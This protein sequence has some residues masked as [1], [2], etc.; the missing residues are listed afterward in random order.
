MAHLWA[1]PLALAA[2]ATAAQKAA[3]TAQF[4]ESIK[5]ALPEKFTLRPTAPPEHYLD[6]S[7]MLNEWESGDVQRP[8]EKFKGVPWGVR[9]QLAREKV[10]RP[11]FYVNS[12]VNHKSRK[13]IGGAGGPEW[14]FQAV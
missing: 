1:I 6:T 5:Y 2:Y 4:Q 8:W 14:N 12:H 9:Q 13:F 10:F 7:P 11:L 3:R